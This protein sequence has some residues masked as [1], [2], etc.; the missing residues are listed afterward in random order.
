MLHACHC[1]DLASQLAL[2]RVAALGQVG[3]GLQLSFES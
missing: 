2:A 3:V 1:T